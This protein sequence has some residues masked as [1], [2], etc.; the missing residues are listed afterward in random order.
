MRLRFLIL[1]FLATL[2][3]YAGIADNPPFQLQPGDYRILDL[4]VKQ[5]PLRV[6]ASFQ[7]TE[8]EGSV[9]M[10]LLPF[11][12]FRSMQRG[13]P[14]QALAATADGSSGTFRQTIEEPGIYR[15]VITNR[16]NAKVATVALSVSTDRNPAIVATELPAKRRIV[17]IAVSFLL[18]FAMVGYSGWK[19]RQANQD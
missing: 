3:L 4:R 2:P 5:T 8:G 11:H 12:A 19:L 1:A 13:Q 6:D 16:P 17:V 15:I 7:V 10:E 9:H 18:F 14:H